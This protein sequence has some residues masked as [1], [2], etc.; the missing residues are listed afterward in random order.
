M[1]KNNV[2]GILF[3]SLLLV[4]SVSADVVINEILTNSLAV[5]DT[6]GEYIE[7]FNS[8]AIPVD[9]DG[10]TVKD[11]DANS[12]IIS[13]GGPLEILPSGY[14]VLCRN[15]EIAENGGFTCD[16]VL[17]SFTLGEADDEVI[18]LDST[19]AE[20]DKVEYDNGATFPDPAGASMELGNPALDN[21]D[22]TKWFTATTP[23]GAGDLGTPGA[24]NSV[25]DDENPVITNPYTIPSSPST[26]D[27]DIEFC[28]TIT[29]NKETTD[30]LITLTFDFRTGNMKIHDMTLDPETGDYCGTGSVGTMSTSIQEDDQV[31]YTI[32]ASDA[33]GNEATPA[34]GSFQFIENDAPVATQTTLNN[35]P[36]DEDQTLTVTTSELLDNYV[37]E[38]GDTFE[39]VLSQDVAQGQL[40]LEADGTFV[41]VPPTT[42]P[43]D[44]LDFLVTFKYVVVEDVRIPALTS[45]ETTVIISV[46]AVDD[47]SVIA[48]IDDITSDEDAILDVTLDITD[49]DT[50]V[51]T[52][53]PP[54]LTGLVGPIME[55]VSD[56]WH[57]IWN[58]PDNDDVGTYTGLTIEVTDGTTT[59]T[60]NP[61]DLTITNTNDAPEAVADS[62]TVDED[63]EYSG[64]LTGS[65]VD[66][67]DSFT[68]AVTSAGH[69]TVTIVDADLGTFT[70]QGDQDYNGPDAFDYVITDAAG[71]SAT[72]TVTITVTPVNDAPAFVDSFSREY[73]VTEGSELSFT[74]INNTDFSDVDDEN[75]FILTSD[76]WLTATLEG[77]TFTVVGTP[78]TSDVGLNEITLTL[79][80]DEGA[81]TTQPINVTVVPALEISEDDFIV[82]IDG[83][84]KELD[85]LNVTP[86]SEVVITFTFDNNYHENLGHLQTSA[87]ATT[88]IND[89]PYTGVCEGV[90][91]EDGFW[92]LTS[93]ESATD[94]ITFTIPHD[95]DVTSFDVEVGVEYDDFWAGVLAALGLSDITSEFTQTLTFNVEKEPSA[96]FITAIGVV[97]DTLTTTKLL[98]L[99]LEI[100]NT[101]SQPVLPELLIYNKAAVASSFNEVTG[102]FT[103]FVGGEPEFFYEETLAAIPAAGNRQV[104]LDFDLSELSGSQT[105]Y[106][107]IVFPY[108]DSTDYFV[109]DAVEIDLTLG[110]ALNVPALESEFVIP[111][112]STTST[113]VDLF[114]LTVYEEDPE[115]GVLRNLYDYLT[116]EDDDHTTSFT[117]TDQNTDLISCSVSGSDLT[118]QAPEPGQH[119]TSEVTLQITTDGVS[120]EET[121]TVTVLPALEI[122]TVLVNGVAVTDEST[123]LKPQQ[124]ITVTITVTNNLDRAVTGIEPVVN[125]ASLTLAREAGSPA[126][127]LAAGASTQITLE[128]TLPLALPEGTYAA[129]LSVTG[130]D[131][132][133]TQVRSDAKAFN[134]IIGQD[135]ADLYISDFSFPQAVE[136]NGLTCSEAT[137]VTVTYT[138]RGSNLENDAQLTLRGA[139]IDSEDAQYTVALPEVGV[140]EE[141]THAFTVSTSDLTAG[142]N[143]LTAT[144]TYRDDFVTSSSSTSL[145]KNT[146]ITSV[147]PSEG[148]LTIREMEYVTFTANL[149]EAVSGNLL[150]SVNGLGFTRDDEMTFYS[151][152]I[153]TFEIEVIS[154]NFPAEKRSWT[155]EVTNKPASNLANNIP[156][157]VKNAQLANFDL[158]FS[159]AFG[160]IVFNEPVDISEVNSFVDLITITADTVSID[161]NALPMLDVPATIT[162][163]RNF[164]NHIILSGD[165]GSVPTAVCTTC[166]AVSNVNGFTF[167]VDGFSS[168]KVVSQ[169][170]PAFSAGNIV[171]DNVTRGQS[172]SLP[173]V[174]KNTGTFDPLTS[175]VTSLTLPAKYLAT[176]SEVPATLSPGQEVTATLALTIPADENAGSH[177][178]GVL[179]LV[180]AEHSLD[181]PISVSTKSLLTIE[182]IKINGKTSGDFTIED[183]NEIEVKVQN[184]Y[185][186]DMEDVTVTVTILDVDGDDIDEESD[187]FDLDSGK[188]DEITVEFD[189]SGEDLTED[190]YE[191]EIKVEGTATDDSEHETIETKNVKVDREKH[192]VVLKR[193]ALSNSQLSCSGQTVVSATVENLG[194]SNEDEVE[195]RL[196]NTELGIDLKKSDIEVDKFSSSDNDAKVRFNLNIEAE[197]GSY[198]LT[199]ELYRDGD[200]ET[201]E[202]LQLTVACKV[203]EATAS[204]PVMV[205]VPAAGAQLTDALTQPVQTVATSFRDT[206]TYTIL[207]S[208][209][210]VLLL[211]ACLLGVAVVFKK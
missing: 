137:T 28:A 197:S 69:G 83:V 141:G 211:V 91:C 88:S 108:F 139:N 150:W 48:T 148:H 64:T 89:L 103:S 10:W 98:E 200:F 20:V 39:V 209:L 130:R 13:N 132:S 106:A 35:F 18:L 77:D 111:K 193:V 176:L 51:S 181:V 12:H 4:T 118:C 65:D 173:V 120:F 124:D 14:L 184:D 45:E 110:N 182:S 208:V 169:S 192:K 43:V 90:D 36:T 163:A 38:E 105:L 153:D 167:N 93:G 16:Y 138:N 123:P 159:N 61:F 47:P 190:S 140:N 162:L 31:T 55:F 145:V 175:I 76:A 158:E 34:V 85:D 151:S 17:S 81:T 23:F 188:D 129:S 100:T 86:G 58:T 112:D 99:D 52:F 194:K 8:G 41:Y 29:D 57:L 160:K 201:S 128:D 186:E 126:I 22:G 74:I 49:A 56:A 179:K 156:A 54:T 78:Y 107:Y 142:A 5:S 68:F 2:F 94:V 42:E 116:E 122:D 72:E 180:S 117:V 195:V 189:L 204:A 79:A 15:D 143:T 11:L 149:A 185:A 177:A 136:D 59:I 210:V 104:P 44:G 113:T 71:S 202:E 127:N 198:P 21:N 205:D 46:T 95:I 171:I 26:T 166:Q 125:V 165:F 63:E 27:N 97:D 66:V 75:G 114:T 60:S 96:V 109:G 191:I 161:T 172:V 1:N 82:T 174:I 9:I 25:F 50:D 206:T 115:E 73:T 133:N 7:L 37:D 67:G 187:E 30:F 152:A 131:F 157:N 62:F 207:L 92:V 19:G 33:A 3:L 196:F 203:K 32:T 155:V 119:G 134:L 87:T 170:L 70:Y 101:G 40:T 135:A 6:D 144:L 102:E 164:N 183:L 121:F 80:D 146:C 199:L 154:T 24:Q 178:L 84:S 168:Y 147:T 53:T